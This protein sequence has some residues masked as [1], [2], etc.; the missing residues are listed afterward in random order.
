MQEK[1]THS[2]VTPS[3][4]LQTGK[5]KRSKLCLQCKR[6]CILS[7]KSPSTRRLE[8]GDLGLRIGNWER[9]RAIC[10]LS[11]V[12]CPLGKSRELGLEDGGRKAEWGFKIKE[13]GDRSQESGVRRK[14]IKKVTQRR[15]WKSLS[16]C[17]SRSSSLAHFLRYS[18]S[19][20]SP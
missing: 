13:T 7:F 2:P 3:K 8:A 1:L 17:C 15:S 10:Q 19:R 6:V 16:K 5:L 18:L 20:F 11:V 4:P 14:T 12:G 9:Q